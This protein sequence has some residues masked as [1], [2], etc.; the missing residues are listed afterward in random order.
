MVKIIIGIVGVA[1]GSLITIKSETILKMFGRVPFAE[2]Y[3]GL[4]GGSRTFYKL[5]GVL[6]AVL[7]I[8]L[9]T[10]M[11]Q[12]MILGFLGPLFGGLAG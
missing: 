7:A 9:M 6:I 5:L 3:L 8:L 2:K 12:K 4:E 11:L 10:G 1:I